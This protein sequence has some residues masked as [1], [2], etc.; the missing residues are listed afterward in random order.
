MKTDMKK[1]IGDS[2]GGNSRKSVQQSDSSMLS[3]M[4]TQINR[5]V[6]G[7]YLSST[8]GVSPSKRRESAFKNQQTNIEAV[9]KI[10]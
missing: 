8:P 3:K 6:G 10:G 7:S 9:L 4:K 1:M 5:K 2:L